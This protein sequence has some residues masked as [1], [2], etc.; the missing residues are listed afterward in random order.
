MTNGESVKDMMSKFDKLVKFEGQDFRRWQKKMHFLLTT[1]VVYVLSTP[2][3]VWSENE[4]LETTRKRMK[5]ENDEYIC[6]GHILNGMSDFL[7]DIYQNVESVKALW[8]SLESKYM[9]ED[10]FAT[11]FLVR[12]FMNYKMVDTRPVMEQ[13]HE[14]L[15]ILGQYTQH[16]LMMD[17]A[18]SVAE[19]LRNKELDNNPKGK[20]QIGS[21][22]VNMVERDGA[23]N[24][25]NIKNKRKFKSGDDKFANKKGTITCWKCKKTGHMKKDC[26]SRKGNDGAGSNGSK[27]PE[28]Q[29]DN[30][31][32]VPGIRK[33]LVSEIVLNKCGYK[34]VLENDKYI[35][36]RHGLFVGFGYS[37]DD[38]F[39]EEWFMSIPRPRGMIQPSSGKIAEDEVEGT[40]DVPGPSV[41]RKSTRTRKAKSFGSDF[42][43]YLVEGTRD[44][45][46]S[47]R[48]YCF[49]I[50]ED[51]KTLSEAMA[52]R[53]VAFWK[54]AVQSE[55]DSIMHNDTWELTDLPPGCKELGC[56]WIL[57]RK[58]KVDGSIDKYKAR[59]V[60]QG[61]RQK[62]VIDFFDTYAHVA[63]IST[64]RL[65]LALAAINDLVIHQMDVKIVFLNDQ[66]N[67]TKEFLSSKFD[68]KDLG[69]AEVILGIRIKRGN[70]GT[71]VSQLEYSRAIGCLMYAMISTRLD[72][73]FAVGKLSR[74]TSNPS[75]LH[76]QA[77]GRVFQYMKGTMDYGLT[78]SCY[79]SVIEGYSDASWINNISLV[80][81][82]LG[83][84]SWRRC[85]FL[86]FKETELYYKLNYRV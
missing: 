39:D 64:I 65:L 38:I 37:R 8:E 29:Q 85:Y 30:V 55:I 34:Q 22:S 27:D 82:W 62:K 16:N 18:I 12:S 43:L 72:I 57:K 75:A 79:P 3:P 15:K 1:K 80:Y 66:V 48:G 10:A 78:Y 9:V 49:I 51:P 61:F 59:L 71:P 40:N 56:K 2:S 77:L 28:N 11:K 42:Q 32:Y 13:Y 63:R 74:Y 83:I 46:L 23:K 84:P 54:K 14:M 73:T 41:P 50:E 4:T 68:M 70:N 53:D 44:K 67:K 47:Q 45:T 20:N 81:E 25:N 76:W 52:S 58:M 69:E 35:L 86:G 19:G 6:R 17:E 31:L 24:S 26:R 60:I 33:N 36:S 21:S 5:W 7:F